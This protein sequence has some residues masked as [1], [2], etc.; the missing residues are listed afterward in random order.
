MQVAPNKGAFLFE[1][2]AGRVCERDGRLCGKRRILGYSRLV[3]DKSL[4]LIDIS[5]MMSCC[6]L[7][8]MWKEVSWSQSAFIVPSTDI[9]I[10]V[11]PILYG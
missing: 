3:A 2:V 6:W 5:S 9:I 10:A 4:A 1:V 8:L 11:R 7:T